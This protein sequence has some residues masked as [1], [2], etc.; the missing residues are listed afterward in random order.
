MKKIFI[1]DKEQFKNYDFR[2]T[3]FG[4][5]I[6]SNKILLI[7]DKNQYSL[8]GGGIDFNESHEECLKRE[9][10]EEIGYDI[11]NVRPLFKIDCF[12]LADG[13]WPKESLANFYYVDLNKKNND[14]SESKLEYITIEKAIELLELPYQKKA[15]EILLKEKL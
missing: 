14:N 8:V 1:G 11:K 9:F 15:I 5:N 6:K 4:I 10:K 2:E 3:C 7:Y 13:K 12:W